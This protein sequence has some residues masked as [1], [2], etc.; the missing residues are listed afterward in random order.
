MRNWT[1]GNKIVAT[2]AVLVALAGVTGIVGVIGLRNVGVHFGVVATQSLPQVDALTRIR[3]MVWEIQS[4]SLSYALTGAS[5]DAAGS[6]AH[7]AGLE[8]Q[9]SAAF[10]NYGRTVQPE[11]RQLFQESQTKAQSFVSSCAQFRSLASGGKT[12]EAS[13]YWQGNVSAEWAA[14]RKGLNAEIDFNNAKA[15][16]QFSDGLQAAAVATHLSEFLLFF[17]IVTGA[18]LGFVVTA[19]VNGTLRRSAEELRSTV[20]KVTHSA[21]QVQVASDTLAQ[22]ATT[23][24]ASLEET[25]AS[26]QEIRAMTS[27]NAENAVT[28][29]T[30]MADVDAHVHDANLKLEQL[31]ASMGEIS[32]SSE[33]IAKIIKVIDE[34]AFQTNIL[35]LNAA[36]EAARAG[37]AGLGFAVVADE[38]RNLAQRCAEAAK[39]TTT[40]IA[41][42]VSNAQAGR[43]HLD[44]VA[45]TILG[46]TEN[47]KKVKVLVDEVKQG[48]VEQAKGMEQISTA[49]TEMEAMTQQTAA[50]AAEGRLGQPGFEDADRPDAERSADLGVT[51]FQQDVGGRH[52]GS[53]MASKHSLRK[54]GETTFGGE[55]ER[56]TGSAA[57]RGR[58]QREAPETGARSC[59][60]EQPCRVYL[61]AGRKG[62]SGILKR[63][64]KRQKLTHDDRL[65][66]PR[67]SRPIDGCAACQ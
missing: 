25:S 15:T 50:G 38:V 51:G 66:N 54:A 1:I 44:K 40:L 2:S 49:L 59:C 60:G 12:P 65:F 18:A 5:S 39:N 45:A 63:V 36:V 46:I 20:G 58:T 19:N 62:F 24:A 61:S 52:G 23:Q 13:G 16:G 21:A 14:L 11:E 26:G 32:G 7:I 8:R 22:N 31:M 47:T 29:A 53:S 34:I 55:G 33:R 27:R 37:E 64:F 42:S 28:A 56:W 30:L 57:A 9:L 4:A 48:G 43:T 41:E 67:Y 35:A 10:E 6:G 3:S 17:A